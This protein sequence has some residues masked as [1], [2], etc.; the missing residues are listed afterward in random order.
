MFAIGGGKD[1]TS[2]FHLVY[3]TNMA[4]KK[5]MDMSK[6]QRNKMIEN[7]VDACEELKKN[8]SKYI[9][10]ESPKTKPKLIECSFNLEVGHIKKHIH[11]DGYLAFDKRCLL[12]RTK[13]N[14]IFD[15]ALSDFDQKGFFT[16]KFVPD[17]IARVKSYTKKEGMSLV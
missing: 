8:M 11:V 12:N 17:V 7:I 15:K 6:P 16:C 9:T 5:F 14:E 1:Q 3:N 4:S 10:T 2:Q 13:F